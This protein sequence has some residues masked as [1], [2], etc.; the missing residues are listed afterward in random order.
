MTP[1]SSVVPSLNLSPATV[2]G[3]CR[4][5]QPPPGVPPDPSGSEDTDHA[6]KAVK[7]FESAYGAK[8]GKAVTKGPGSRADGVVMAFKLIESASTDLDYCSEI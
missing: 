7:A 4:N 5:A 6:L 8:L 3:P 2:S 1:S